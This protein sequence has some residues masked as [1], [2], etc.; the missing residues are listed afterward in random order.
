MLKQAEDETTVGEVCRYVRGTGLHGG[1]ARAESRASAERRQHRLD[2][3]PD[4]RDV[5]C[6][7]IHRVDVAERQFARR[8]EPVA[9]LSA[10]LTPPVAIG[11]NWS[12]EEIRDELENNAQDV[13]GYVVR[14][15]DQ[16][17]DC[18]KVPDIH[19]VALMEDRA[20]LRISAQ[21][22]ANWLL[23]GIASRQ[24]VDLALA[25]MASKVDLQRPAIRCIALCA[26]A[27]RP[28][29]LSKPRMRLC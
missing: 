17:L 6:N 12:P 22:I 8:Q 27:N 7:A 9:P 1:Y 19:N 24:D 10:L 21:H 29:L 28:R 4:G 25:R 11:R 14:W 20:T 26:P 5:A 18:S 2:A 16:A 13:L 3:K 15:V 23:H